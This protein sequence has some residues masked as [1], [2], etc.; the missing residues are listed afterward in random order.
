M[1]SDVHLASLT[2]LILRHGLPDEE[3]MRAMRASN[4]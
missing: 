1:I 4:R 2:A 3:E